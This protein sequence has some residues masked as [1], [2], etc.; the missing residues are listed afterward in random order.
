MEE[1]MNEDTETPME[2]IPGKQKGSVKYYYKGYIYHLDDRYDPGT[3]RCCERG[4]AFKCK[5]RIELASDNFLNDVHEVT[6]KH[7]HDAD[8]LI[9][10][11]NQFEKDVLTLC[12]TTFLDITDIFDNILSKQK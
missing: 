2:E 12:R 10:L 4:T 7:N 6:G 8:F 3:L 9:P 5:A 11:K 1:H